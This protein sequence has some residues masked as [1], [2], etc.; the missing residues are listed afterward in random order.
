M[1]K[2]YLREIAIFLVASF[3]VW[4]ALAFVFK[5]ETFSE[6]QAKKAI[7]FVQD[8]ESRFEEEKDNITLDMDEITLIYPEKGFIGRLWMRYISG[9]THEDLQAQ[10][11]DMAKRSFPCASLNSL[12][13]VET[14]RLHVPRHRIQALLS[15]R[16]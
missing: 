4:T 16:I 7:N 14:R 3:L 6:D 10:V 1:R 8:N 12:K 9:P 13:S 11:M 5:I 15:C 2:L